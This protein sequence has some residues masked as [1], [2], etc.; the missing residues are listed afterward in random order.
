MN[1]SRWDDHLQCLEQSTNL[2]Y[3]SYLLWL[4][5]ILFLS[6]KLYSGRDTPLAVNCCLLS[7]NCFPPANLPQLCY[8]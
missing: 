4:I 5:L 3:L 1:F 7:V 8:N 2:N 6:S